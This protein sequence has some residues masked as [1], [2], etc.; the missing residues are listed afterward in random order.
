MPS[1][2]KGH[3]SP[4]RIPTLVLPRPYLGLIDLAYRP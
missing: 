2:E 1:V 3:L 4:N